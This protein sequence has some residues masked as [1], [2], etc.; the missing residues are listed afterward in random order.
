MK[1]LLPLILLLL[2]ILYPKAIVI[3]QESQADDG[4]EEALP[5]IIRLS[6][7][8]IDDLTRDEVEMSIPI[9]TSREGMEVR[10]QAQGKG[11]VSLQWPKSTAEAKFIVAI[12]GNLTASFSADGG[13][14]VVSAAMSAPYT[15]QKQFRLVDGNFEA[16]PASSTVEPSIRIVGICTKRSGLIGKIVCRVAQRLVSEKRCEMYQ[17][18]TQFAEQMVS[19]VFDE[20]SNSLLAK[21]E[22]VTR[23]KETV[24]ELTPDTQDWKFQMATTPTS[25]YVGAGP[26]NVQ[27]DVQEMEEEGSSA[28]IEAWLQTTPLEQAFLET[29]LIDWNV[30][31]DALREFLPEE[32]ANQLAED[33]SLER[34]GGWTVIMVGS[35]RE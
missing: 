14:A 34:R 5:V 13:P 22:E 2:L 8:L 23:I 10:G 32:E 17:I 4:S 6:D 33:V 11:E 19:D 18:V 7:K 9:Q 15:T 20:E 16:A 21:L 12:N 29:I 3:A 25:L 24:A 1:P 30:A 35:K 26:T 28:L 31:N 27:L